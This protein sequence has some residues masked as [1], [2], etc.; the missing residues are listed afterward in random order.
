MDE[1]INLPVIN[2]SRYVKVKGFY[3]ILS[4]HYDALL[5]MGD[6]NILKAFFYPLSTN[7]FKLN[8]IWCA[9]M[10]SEKVGIWKLSPTVYKSGKRDTS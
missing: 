10:M 6:T 7:Q 5:T 4:K 1:I 3:E 2:G 9:R 8:P